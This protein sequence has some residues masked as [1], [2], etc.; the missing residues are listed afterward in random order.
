MV[1]IGKGCFL[2]ARLFILKRVTIADDAVV[3]AGAVVNKN[4]PNEH[5]AAGNPAVC[6]PLPERWCQS[7]AKI[8][9][10]KP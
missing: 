3:A 9:N 10:A 6:R 2:S 7:R 8:G 4:V 1:R 5:L